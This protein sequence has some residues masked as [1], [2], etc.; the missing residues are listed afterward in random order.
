MTKAIAL[1]YG[2]DSLA[3]NAFNPLALIDAFAHP[4]MIV[5]EALR[6]IHLRYR[7]DT[8]IALRD[9]FD[10]SQ[11]PLVFGIL[12]GRN[13]VRASSASAAQLGKH[14]RA[15]IPAQPSFYNGRSGSTDELLEDIVFR[16]KKDHKP[17]DVFL[18]TASRPKKL[19][20]YTR[21][22]PAGS[23]LIVV[24]TPPNSRGH[25]SFWNMM[26]DPMLH[27]TVAPDAR[28]LLNYYLICNGPM[29][30]TPHIAVSGKPQRHMN[31]VWE[32]YVQNNPATLA[33]RAAANATQH[34]NALMPFISLHDHTRL[35]N[36]RQYIG[37]L[38]PKAKQLD[39]ACQAWA[40]E[41]MWEEMFGPH[42]GYSRPKFA[43]VAAP[44]VKTKPA[45][46]PAPAQQT[47]T[48]KTYVT[49]STGA[50]ASASTDSSTAPARRPRL[51]SSQVG[52]L[53]K[54]GKPLHQQH[55]AVVRRFLHKG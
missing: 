6:D 46:A 22:M 34:F 11:H 8:K 40:L 7:A 44:R 54:P 30:G 4:N 39:G 35:A 20:R 37:H 13:Y 10:I 16:A 52:S 55:P 23:T 26:Q 53:Y 18:L 51:T 45:A 14:Q 25:Q 17:V 31:D 36:A 43:S 49:S 24:Q 50:A 47:I 19:Q 1:I 33:G 9:V 29:V 5:C 48:R 41:T 42:S 2:R 12:N 21:Q 28:S 38:G 3:S 27:G 32:Y 15:D